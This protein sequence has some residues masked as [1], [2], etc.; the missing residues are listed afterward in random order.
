MGGGHKKAIEEITEMQDR[1]GEI[2]IRLETPEETA[3]RKA[4]EAAK[5]GYCDWATET[6]ETLSTVYLEGER[7]IKVVTVEVPKEL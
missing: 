3:A 5:P 1:G 2:T 4:Q 6:F 7:V